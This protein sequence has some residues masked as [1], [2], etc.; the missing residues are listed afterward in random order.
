MLLRGAR[1]REAK[2][3]ER[4]QWQTAHLLGSEKA[5]RAMLDRMDLE[6]QRRAREQGKL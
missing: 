6:R 1:D 5:G 2:E 4:M 3:W